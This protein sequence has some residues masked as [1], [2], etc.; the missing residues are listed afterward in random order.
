[1]DIK[2]LERK[3]HFNTPKAAETQKIGISDPSQSAELTVVDYVSQG[4]GVAGGALQVV[5]K[6]PR[7][8]IAPFLLPPRQATKKG[9]LDIPGM[10]KDP[11]LTSPWGMASSLGGAVFLGAVAGLCIGGPLAVAVGAGVGA[12]LFRFVDDKLADRAR[13]EKKTPVFVEGALAKGNAQAEGAS[14]LGVWSETFTAMSKGSYI[15]VRD[16]YASK[17]K[18]KFSPE[19]KSSESRA[20]GDL[21]N[22]E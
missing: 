8:A 10:A 6:T 2:R 1:M 9:E 18:E 13:S 21:A 17:V 22:S 5:L 16:W 15:E 20:A 12:K 11:A 7:N 3:Q 4:V 19:A 14:G